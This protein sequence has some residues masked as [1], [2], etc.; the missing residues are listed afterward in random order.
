MSNTMCLSPPLSVP[1]L[2]TLEEVRPFL[3]AVFLSCRALS[4]VVVLPSNL[5]STQPRDRAFYLVQALRRYEWLVGFTKRICDRRGI[6]AQEVFEEE[7]QICRDMVQLLPGKIDRMCY[8]GEG[9]LSL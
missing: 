5:P 2:I 4:K 1:A 3:N 6:S 9:G 8:L 7:L